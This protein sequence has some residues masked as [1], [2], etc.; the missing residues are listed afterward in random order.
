M[1]YAAVKDIDSSTTFTQYGSNA[2]LNASVTINP[3]TNHH[4]VAE[5][6]IGANTDVHLNK[7][8]STPFAPTDSTNVNGANVTG[9]GLKITTK[10]TLGSITGFTRNAGA[11]T[12]TGNNNAVNSL[13]NGAT[14]HPSGG[15]GTN[16]A[17]TTSGVMGEV[18]GVEVTTGGTAIETKKDENIAF[19]PHNVRSSGQNLKIEAAG[20]MGFVQSIAIGGTNSAHGGI[21]VAKNAALTQST[22]AASATQF[23]RNGFAGSNLAITT[24]GTMGVVAAVSVTAGARPCTRTKRILV[25]SPR[26]EMDPV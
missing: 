13:K 22:T 14:V 9:S 21:N 8:R 15:N 11:L 25:Y 18:M 17:V 12:I 16:C 23:K 6:S 3:V 19:I 10:G 4:R 26:V 2:A 5:L 1:R 24:T 7:N 20:V